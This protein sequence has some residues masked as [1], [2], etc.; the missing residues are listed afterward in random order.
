MVVLAT[1]SRLNPAA[2]HIGVGVDPPITQERPVVAD[3]LD[4]GGITLYD[5]DLFLVVATLDREKGPAGLTAF[6]I[7]RDTPGLDVDSS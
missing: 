3:F 4:A 2:G 5:H 7:D 1:G 6:L